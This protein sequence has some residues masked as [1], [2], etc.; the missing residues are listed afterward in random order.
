MKKIVIVLVTVFALSGFSYPG[1]RPP[2]GKEVSL[3]ERSLDASYKFW[4]HREVHPC[5][6]SKLTVLV[7]NDLG[8]DANGDDANGRSIDCTIWLLRFNLKYTNQYSIWT[9]PFGKLYNCS[10][11][12]HELGHTAGLGHT[13]IGI[14]SRYSNTIAWDCVKEFKVLHKRHIFSMSFM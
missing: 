5:P 8:H 12:T 10:V 11:I 7:A 14:M 1:E 9:N 4:N 6:R 3:I 13:E 2:K